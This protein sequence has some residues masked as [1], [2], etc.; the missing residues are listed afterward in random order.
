MKVSLPF[1]DAEGKRMLPLL[2]IRWC[3]VNLICIL[4]SSRL[5]I[6]NL[7]TINGLGFPTMRS[8]TG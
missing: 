2:K 3:P 1:R 7:P 8:G 6:C 5:S 4:I